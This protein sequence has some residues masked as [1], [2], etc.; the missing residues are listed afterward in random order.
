MAIEQMGQLL[1]PFF[2]GNPLVLEM[3]KRWMR[4]AMG[5]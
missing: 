4:R 2:N 1:L 5:R 3:V